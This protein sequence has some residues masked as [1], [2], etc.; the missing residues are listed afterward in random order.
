MLLNFMIKYKDYKAQRMRNLNPN[1]YIYKYIPLKYLLLML[2]NKKLRVDKVSTWED[3][4]ENFFMKEEFYTYAS[5]YQKDISIS[6]EEISKRIYGQSWTLEEESDA[7][8]RIYSCDYCKKC[9]LE[10][11]K[12]NLEERAV[13]V[14]V[15]IDSLFS[16]VYT[17]DHCMATTSIGEV[18]YKTVKEID[19][20]RTNLKNVSIEFPKLSEECLFIKRDSFQHEKEVRII[21]SEATDKPAKDF[22]EF[23]I[24]DIGIFEEYILDPRLNQEDID[25]T[26]KLISDCGVDKTLI[27][28]SILYDFLPQ[29]IKL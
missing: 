5:F 3:P 4:Y 16:L 27:K 11:R 15:K 28:R 24:S 23:D 21:I 1:T 18:Q 10:D 7:M 26:I 8:W 12:P 9:N 6:T 13:K 25:S 20:W 2:E 22:L 14:K 17:D 19:E 29:T